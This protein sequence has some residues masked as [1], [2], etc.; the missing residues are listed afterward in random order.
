MRQIRT[1]KVN[2]VIFGDGLRVRFNFIAFPGMCFINEASTRMSDPSIDYFE[3]SIPN[4]WGHIFLKI[5]KK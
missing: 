1:L 3:M 5:L 4:E 2:V